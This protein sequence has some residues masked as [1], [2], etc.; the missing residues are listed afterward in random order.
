V[1]LRRNLDDAGNPASAPTREPRERF[2]AY[3]YHE[4]GK[5]APRSM[6]GLIAL[7]RSAIALARRASPRLFSLVVVLQLLSAVLLGLQVFLAKEAIQAVLEQSRAGGDL[8]AALPPI[9]GLAVVTAATGLLSGAQTHLQRLLGEK[10]QRTSWDAILGVTTA[11]GLTEFESPDFFDDLQR[12]R[13]NAL[14]RPLTLVTGLVQVI[15][16]AVT[17]VVLGVAVFAI[18]PLL[19]PI[20]VLATIP[21]T[22]LARRSGRAEYEFAVRQT[23]QRRRRLYLEDILSGR[24]EAKEI[25]AFG[26]AGVLRDRW[27]YSY[28]RYFSDLDLH[29]RRRVLLDVAAALITALGTSAS[30]VLLV[31]LVFDGRIALAAAGGALIA[32]RLLGGRIQTLING[33]G[34]LFESSLFMHD[35]ELFLARAPARHVDGQPGRP[36]GPLDELRAEEITFRYPGSDRDAL[37]EVSLT[38]RAGEVIALVGENGSGKT[39]LAK[40]IAQVFE[41]A[42][43]RLLWNGVDCGRLDPATV[44][45]Q[46]GVVFQDFVQYQLTARENVGLGRPEFGDDLDRVIAAARRAGAH[47]HL[48]ALP[49]GYDTT[50]GKE[51]FG[52]YD[53]SGGQWQRVALA[54]LFFRDAALLILDEPTASLDARSEHQ[55]FERVQELARGRSVLLISHRFSTVK[56]ADRIYVLDR[57][58]IIEQGSHDDLIALGGRY[59]ELFELQARSYR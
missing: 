43:G 39:T 12:V 31:V 34:A 5:A 47:E 16:G 19:V 37:S 57:G 42:S 29:I 7:S 46:V 55:V 53:L 18:A 2:D 26:L 9:I 52:G 1:A 23:P 54:R 56:S 44:R 30:L 8:G 4:A 28:R 20:L 24:D 58:H 14:T 35:L 33:V 36:A 10:V 32:I 40:L 25:R 48:A 6:R 22:W 13:A 17:V 3:R 41:P 11:V 15:G 49:D 50:L 27:E 45:A 51:F 59:A 21:T 38:I